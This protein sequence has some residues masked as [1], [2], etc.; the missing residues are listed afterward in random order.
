MTTTTTT[1]TCRYQGTPTVVVQMTLTERG[2]TWSPRGWAT[3]GDCHVPLI[4][5]SLVTV[6]AAIIIGE[7]GAS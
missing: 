6:V 2:I 3:S 4:H 5:T 1:R 7:L